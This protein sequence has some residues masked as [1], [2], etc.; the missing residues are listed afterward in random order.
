VG[1]RPEDLVWMAQFVAFTSQALVYAG[2]WSHVVT[3]GDRAHN[4]FPLHLLAPI[5]KRDPDMAAPCLVW[6]SAEV[7]AVK[8]GLACDALARIHG[9]AW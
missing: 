6:S 7:C 1:M 3:L 9:A 8:R 2:K 5:D 4:L